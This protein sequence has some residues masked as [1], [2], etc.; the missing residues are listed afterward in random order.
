MRETG[1]GKN[2]TFVQEDLSKTVFFS[3]RHCF[4]MQRVNSNRSP[5]IPIFV[6]QKRNKLK[7]Y[8]AELK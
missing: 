7:A 5:S 4:I 3:L 8:I 2:H 1:A 6:S